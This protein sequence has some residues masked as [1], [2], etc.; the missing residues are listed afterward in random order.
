MTREHLLRAAARQFVEGDVQHW[1]LPH[2]G[3]GVRTRISDDRAWLA[4]TVAHY[5][6]ATGDAA[7][8][9]E[10]VPFLEGQKLEPGEH[11]SFFQPTISDETAT[12]FEHCARALDQ[13]LAVGSHGLPLIGTGDW[14][15]GMNRVGEHGKGESVWLG[16]LLHAALVAFA[17]FADERRETTRAATWRAH[18]AALHASLEGEAWDGAW[19]RRGWFDDGTPLGSAGGEACRID[20][21]A[22]S[23]AAISGAA[24]PDRATRAMA[25]V[26][27]ELI[28]SRDGLALLFAPPFDKTSLDPGYIKGYPP[29]IR[30]NGGQYTHAAAWSV[31]AFA[32]LGEGDKA[33]GLFSLLNPI[34]HARTRAEVHRY[35]VEPYVVA[36]DVYAAPGHVGRGGWTWYTG[37]A[38]WMQRAGIESILGARMQGEFLRL[39]PCIPKDWPGFEMTVRYRTAQYE[40]K[41]ENP[42]GVSG[43]IV[44]ATLDGAAVTGQPLCLPLLDDSKVHHIQVTLGMLALPGAGN[45]EV[46]QSVGSL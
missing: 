19:Y 34:N 29:G 24:D 27:R 38:G 7:V 10:V 46:R 13:S 40:I 2:S 26:E 11:D 20:S 14:N 39:D 1:W 22:Q 36:A 15:D 37:S 45:G 8:L 44:S 3:Q 32:A 5:V 28:R 4:Y 41:V 12:L 43:G 25:A 21:I 23:W 17:P 35:K 16:W 33:A 42:N 6:D 31:M 18:A 9:G 30:E